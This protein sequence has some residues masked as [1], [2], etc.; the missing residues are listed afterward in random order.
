MSGAI[1]RLKSRRDSLTAASVVLLTILAA[2][3][4][5]WLWVACGMAALAI[6]SALWPQSAA[7]QSSLGENA[8]AIGTS[9]SQSETHRAFVDGIPDAALL[10]TSN[11]V[12]T[13][14][15][16]VA[17]VLA[18]IQ[19]GRPL[20][21]WSRSP[22]LLSA[23]DAAMA[24]GARQRCSIRWFTPIDRTLDVLVSPIP[25]SRRLGEMSILVIL[26]DLTEQE[27]IA[28]MRAD[29][30]ANASHELRTPLASIKGFIETLQGA[31]RDD[32]DAR[33]RF[34]V[35]MEEQAARM[36]RLI[37]DLLSLSRIEMREHLAPLERVDF[38][39]LVIDACNTLEP[40]AKQAGIELRTTCASDLP[41]VAGDRDELTQVVQ[42]LTQNAIKY[43][44]QGGFV[45]V[46]VHADRGKVVLTVTDNG[47]GIAAEH[48][49]RLTERF[50]RVSPKQSRE[51]GGT[52]LGLAI[53]KHILN[54]HRGELNIEST[55]GQ[56][57][58]FTVA[59]PSLSP[60]P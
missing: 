2:G 24:T 38:A 55:L 30:V 17:H 28:R 43:G 48:L 53:V 36:S 59:L 49:P 57:S 51:R 8:D 25:A 31:A 13:F 21:H 60:P 41:A 9:P 1:G 15:N 18:P 16:A 4:L 6:W 47:I 52:G 54:R 37:A 56:G 40:A 22:E 14:A 19:I 39:S 26:R 42:N 12:V 45:E 58:R 44:R 23:I 5:S 3:Q 32:P 27:Q 35:I 46:C 33:D 10:L 34:L 50:Y 11:S 29:F 7:R 20:S